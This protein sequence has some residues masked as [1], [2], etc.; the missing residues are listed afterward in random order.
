MSFIIS[1]QIKTY[2]IIFLLPANYEQLRVV[3]PKFGQKLQI[4]LMINKTLLL[5]QNEHC[6]CVQSSGV[7]SC[8]ADVFGSSVCSVPAANH[9]VHE[10]KQYEMVKAWKYSVLTDYIYCG[11]FL[12]LAWIPIVKYRR[13][14]VG[15]EAYISPTDIY[16]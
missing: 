2:K 8:L 5:F 15:R 3:T 6:A 11:Y 1:P 4:S 9:I 13:L 10:W 7:F 16:I 12:F 14:P